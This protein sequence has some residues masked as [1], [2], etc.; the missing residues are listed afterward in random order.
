MTD[1]AVRPEVEEATRLPE[2]LTIGA[3]AKWSTGFV[4]FHPLT[5]QEQYLVNE[6]WIVALTAIA[7]KQEVESLGGLAYIVDQETQLLLAKKG[8]K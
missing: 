2:D 4:G 5:H 7:T 3:L 6:Q 1:V 8:R